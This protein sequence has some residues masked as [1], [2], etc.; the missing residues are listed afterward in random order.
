MSLCAVLVLLV[1]NNDGTWRMCVDC[2]AINNVMEKRPI[3]NFSE[4]LNE[5]TLNYP[6]YDKE[7]YALVRALGT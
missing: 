6:R 4:K 2:R 3:A 5:T 7:F 1:P